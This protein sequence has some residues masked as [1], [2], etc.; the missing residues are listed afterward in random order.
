M[1]GS[2]CARAGVARAIDVTHAA[3]AALPALA[4]LSIDP[5]LPQGGSQSEPPL[6][7]RITEATRGSRPGVRREPRGLRHRPVEDVEHVVAQTEEV[8]GHDPSMAAPPHGF[9]AHDRATLAT[10]DGLQAGEAAREFRR[11]HGVVRIRVEA[12]VLPEAI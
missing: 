8:I 11:G 6:R 9:R 12:L 10:A 1:R 7:R 2:S 5:I 3:I 4:F